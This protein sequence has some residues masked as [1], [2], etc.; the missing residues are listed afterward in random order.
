M[1]CKL[2]LQEKLRDLRDECKLK[3]A[4]LAEVTGIPISTLQRIE[5]DEDIRVGYQDVVTLANYY[6]V[7]TDYLFGLTDNRLH[8]N[9]A[10]DELGL[11]DAAVEVLK[12]KKLNNRLVSELLSSLDAP[13]LFSAMEVY[14]DRKMLPQMNALNAV[15]KFAEEKLREHVDAGD[16]EQNLKILQEAIV[17][18][19][20]YLRFRITE[21]FGVLVKA[22]FEAH[23]KDA[24]SGEQMD[25]VKEIGDGY[26][27]YMENKEKA[28][29]Q[30]AKLALLA[31]QIGLNITKLT[32]DEIAV[33]M[34]ALQ[35]SDLYKRSK[36]RK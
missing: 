22:M 12:D 28:G 6:K 14:I 23:K 35:D 36:R 16:D 32:D 9:V 11:T 24:L 17:D 34:K 5:S 27:F 3:L 26:R 25:I 30:R 7:S 33:L 29:A 15:Y 1:K 10:I 13:Q 31:K 4:D 21:R 19:D 20:E 8:R 2:T 18:E